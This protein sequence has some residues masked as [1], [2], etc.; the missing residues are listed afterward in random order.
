M[1][2]CLV[3]PYSTSRAA[4]SVVGPVPSGIT[5]I[6]DCYDNSLYKKIIAKEMESSGNKFY[7]VTNLALSNIN[8]AELWLDCIHYKL[9]NRISTLSEVHILAFFKVIE[10]QLFITN[11]WSF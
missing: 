1:A 8:W 4:S 9:C 6:N 10:F 2:R 11:T 7:L 3:D 5:S